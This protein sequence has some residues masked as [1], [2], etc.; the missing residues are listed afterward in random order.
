[1]LRSLFIGQYQPFHLGHELVLRRA[2]EESDEVIIAIGSADQSFTSSNPFTAGERVEMISYYLDEHFPDYKYYVIP[3]SDINRN[4]LWVA[5]VES[6]C[7][8]FRVVYANNP[9]VKMLFERKG[10]KVKETDTTGTAGLAS[11]ST[12]REMIRNHTPGWEDLVPYEIEKCIYGINGTARIR[13][14]AREEK[15]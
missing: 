13:E 10:Y 2:F 5:H 12:I 1:M 9:L 6:L 7:P 8:K 15:R 4:D 3:V 11:S 14:L